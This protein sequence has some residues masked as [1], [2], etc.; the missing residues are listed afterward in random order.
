[1]AHH[2]GDVYTKASSY[3][4]DIYLLSDSDELCPSEQTAIDEALVNNSAVGIVSGLYDEQLSIIMAS[5][6]FLKGLGYTTEYFAG[7]ENPALIHLIYEEDQKMFQGEAFKSLSGNFEFRALNKDGRQA[8]VYAYKTESTNAR[9]ER[10]WV[11]STRV[12]YETVGVNKFI[13]GLSHLIE[14]YILCDLKRDKYEFYSYNNGETYLTRGV[15]SDLI[16]GMTKEYNLT[17]NIDILKREFSKEAIRE[18]FSTRESLYR[19]DYS[20]AD[21][22]VFYRLAIVPQKFDGDEPR[23]YIIFVMEVTEAHREEIRM[24]SALADAY[25]SANKANDAKTQFLSN[26]SHDIRTPMNAIIGMTAIASAHIDDRERA[27]DALGKITTSSRHLLGLINEV[28]DMN[29]IERGKMVLNNEEFSL[30]DLVDNMIEMVKPQVI[31]RHQTLEVHVNNIKHEEVIGD[32]LRIQQ[33]FTNIMSNAVKYTDDKG[34]IEVTISELPTHKHHVGCFEFV[35]KD[36]GIGMSQEFLET[37]FDPFA[38]AEDPNAT[39]VQGTGLGMSIAHNIVQM[40]DG[41]IKVESELGKGST[42]T[43]TI[44]MQLQESCDSD[45]SALANLPVLVVD[46]DIDSCEGTVDALESIGMQGEWVDNG[47]EAIARVGEKHGTGDDFYAVIV[48]WKMPG[49]DGVETARHIRELVGP[50]LTIIMLTAFDF[51]EIE[52]EARAAGVNAFISKPL[53]R[54]RLK[55]VFMGIVTGTNMAEEIVGGAAHLPIGDY[56]GKR[57]LVVEDNMLNREI[58]CEILGETNCKIETAVNGKIAVDMVEEHEEG[59]FDM[60]FMDIQMPVMNGYDATIAI[61]SLPDGKGATLPI[62]ALTANAFAE[63]V[64]AAKN[65]GANEHVAKPVDVARLAEVM[66]TWIS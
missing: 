35:V 8:Y 39:K 36:N 34:K 66:R 51:G 57:V 56:S 52:E 38:R 43:T 22:K 11:L 13:S 18:R 12:S 60:V 55:S 10:Q 65:A 26:M 5:T 63:D 19:F 49:M 2:T 1:M 7:L 54:S 47:K 28:L 42:F 25:Q 4:E 41:D 37:I 64:V 24:R 48:D 21:E 31:A 27:L 33:V 62:V 46:D 32:S 23:E 6:F 50:E 30:P 58:M 16:E 17:S 53:F 3:T 20:S 59:Y 9:G 45:D 61:R 40:M 14:G 15:Y 44:Y 29:R